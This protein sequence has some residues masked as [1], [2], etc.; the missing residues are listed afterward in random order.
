MT[1]LIRCR[2]DVNSKIIIK[3]KQ[4]DRHCNLEVAKGVGGMI[5]LSLYKDNEIFRIDGSELVFKKVLVKDTE[6]YVYST[7]RTENITWALDYKCAKILAKK[8][9]IRV[10]SKTIKAAYLDSCFMSQAKRKENSFWAKEVLRFIGSVKVE[11]DGK[12]YEFDRSASIDNVPLG[13][14][15]YAAEMSIKRAFV[16]SVVE[17]L[18]IEEFA[19]D[20]ELPEFIQANTKEDVSESLPFSDSM[21]FPDVLITDLQKESLKALLRKNKKNWIKKYEKLTSDQAS[22][23]IKDLQ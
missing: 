11:H 1:I 18:E 23:M 3:G 20:S 22:D 15:S 6:I 17:L 9:G 19:P 14:T 10:K 12:E 2:S 16:S 5:D 7:G 8:F 13:A 4:H 21:K